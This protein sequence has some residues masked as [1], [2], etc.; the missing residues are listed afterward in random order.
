MRHTDAAFVSF[1]A[2][3]AITG[4]ACENTENQE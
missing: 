4:L 1:D 2:D 3:F